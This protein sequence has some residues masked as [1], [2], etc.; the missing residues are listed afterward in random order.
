MV[1]GTVVT[2][3]MATATALPTRRAAAAIAVEA[4]P[5]EA[6][7]RGHAGL[8]PVQLS[9]IRQ[10]RWCPSRRCGKQLKERRRRGL[11]FGIASSAT[12]GMTDR[13]VTSNNYETLAFPRCQLND[14]DV[15]RAAVERLAHREQIT[16]L[17][18]PWGD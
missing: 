15:A 18:T 8:A 4:D 7:V 11:T 10:H 14:S 16:L 3:V 6:E 9:R 13:D 17:L 12:H 1:V 5:A 2:V